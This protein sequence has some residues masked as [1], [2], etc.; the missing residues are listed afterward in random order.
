M[1]FIRY[2]AYD[3]KSIVNLYKYRHMP[4][5]AVAPSA[6]SLFNFLYCSRD[7]IP[8]LMVAYQAGQTLS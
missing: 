1:S 5:L 8:S 4:N 7:I 3:K 6:F 2:M